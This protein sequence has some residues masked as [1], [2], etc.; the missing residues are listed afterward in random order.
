MVSENADMALD[1]FIA[2]NKIKGSFG[3]GG[4]RGGGGGRGG[5]RRGGR[6][7]GGDRGGD[8]VSRS[9]DRGAI[10]KRG[11]GGGGGFSSRRNRNLPER[12]EH[13]MYSGGR[14]SSGGNKL[15]VNNLDFGVTDADMEE[16]FAEFGTLRK[17]SVLYDRSGRSTGSAEIEFLRA[18]DA[19][20]AKEQYHQVPLDGR[21]MS[22]TIMGSDDGDSGRRGGGFRDRSP[23][24]NRNRGGG[25]GDRDFGE[26]N[27]GGGGNRR[28]G[29]NGGGGRQKKEEITQE[30]LDAEMDDYLNEKKN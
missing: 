14:Q 17:A 21:A 4:A 12:W 3:K 30:Q 25:G 11:G 26:R 10:N 2:K 13:D 15:I 16:L 28:R 8:R 20:Q 19:R 18:S 6:G 27:G 5:D 1:D 22:I 23:R 9:G 29:G 24:G 7:R